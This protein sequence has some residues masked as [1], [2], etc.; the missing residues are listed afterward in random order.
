MNADG[1]LTG[2]RCLWLFVSFLNHFEYL[3]V[4][5]VVILL[6][7]LEIHPANKHVTIPLPFHFNNSHALYSNYLHLTRAHRRLELP[8]ARKESPR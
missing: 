1:L 4:L 5:R 2:F 8:P 3:A 7:L 6:V